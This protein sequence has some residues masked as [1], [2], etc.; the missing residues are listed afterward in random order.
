MTAVEKASKKTGISKTYMKYII[1]IIGAAAVYGIIIFLVQR[2]II[3]SYSLRIVKSAGI[4]MIAAFGLNLI[5][6]FTGQLTMGHAAFMSIGAYFSAVMTQNFNAPFAISLLVGVI[7][8]GIIAGLIGYPILR[9]RGDYLA[10][11]TLGFGEIVKV[12]I[13]N[14]DYVGGARGMTSI[15]VKSSFMIIFFCAVA[16]FSLLRNLIGTTKGRAIKAIREDEIASEAMGI[17]PTTYKMTAFI[18]GSAMAGLAGGLYAHFNTFI[19]PV[20]FNYSKSFDMI[21]YVVLGGMGSLSGTV[22]GTLLLVILPESLRALAEYRMLIYA[23]MLVSLMIFRPSGILGTKEI[24]VKSI[25]N[26]F[27]KLGGK[28]KKTAPA[29]G[30]VGE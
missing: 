29:D 4:F 11:C 8:A 5:L 27:K 23:V 10:I 20:T 12:V 19:D 14:I 24:T 26:L 28:G 13:Q 18:L 21:T 25:V 15:P 22:V 9:L 17:N 2:G 6:G 7:A 30:K 1:D 16:C 3:D